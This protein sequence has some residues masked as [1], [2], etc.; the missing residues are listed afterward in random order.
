MLTFVVDAAYENKNFN[1][2]RDIE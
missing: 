1:C 2:C